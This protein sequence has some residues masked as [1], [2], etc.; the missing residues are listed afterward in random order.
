MREASDA[1]IP[2]TKSNLNNY[3]KTPINSWASAVSTFRRGKRRKGE[4]KKA[5]IL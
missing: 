5:Q 1:R 3:N 4:K 2:Q